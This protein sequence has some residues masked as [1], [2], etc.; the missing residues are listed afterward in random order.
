MSG[1][2]DLFIGDQNVV[3]HASKKI[4]QVAELDCLEESNVFMAFHPKTPNLKNL[5][6]KLNEELSKEENKKLFEKLSNRYISE[7]RFQKKYPYL[8]NTYR[9]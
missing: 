3:R 2:I 4:P 7:K 6:K 5:L 1:R 9:R 8:A